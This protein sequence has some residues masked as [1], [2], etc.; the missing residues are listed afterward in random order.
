MQ[1]QYWIFMLILAILAM[2]IIMGRHKGVHRRQDFYMLGTVIIASQGTRIATAWLTA[3]L[4]GLLIPAYKNALVAAPFWTSL[5]GLFLVAEFLQYWIHRLAHNSKKHPL[6][7]GMHRTHH[8]APYVNVTLMWR[9]NLLWPFVHSYTW[10]AAAAIYLG[11]YAQAAAF[12]TVIMAWN[13]LTHSDWRWDDAIIAHVPGG[14]KLVAAAEW[15]VVTPRLHHV[16]HGYGRDGANYRNFCTFFSFYDRLFGTLHVPEGRPWR[17][18]MPGGDPH[19]VRQ[20]LFPLV[21]L[22]KSKKTSL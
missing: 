9:T 17:Y 16:H 22:A 15:I 21:P 4:I 11:L 8:S 6:L 14:A 20:L 1:G 19:W 5:L 3:T 10:V 18:G 13:A 7:F 12:Y 2:E